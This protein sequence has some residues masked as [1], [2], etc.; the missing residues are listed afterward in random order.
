EYSWYNDDG[1]ENDNQLTLMLFMG[2]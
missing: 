1:R 2:F